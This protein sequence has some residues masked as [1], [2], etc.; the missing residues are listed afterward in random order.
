MAHK[1][2]VS[3]VGLHCKHAVHYFFCIQIRYRL[4][5]HICAMVFH[6]S[7]WKVASEIVLLDHAFFQSSF[8]CKEFLNSLNYT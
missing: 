8:S 1:S 3:A 7:L 2:G 6:Q 4:F 5:C